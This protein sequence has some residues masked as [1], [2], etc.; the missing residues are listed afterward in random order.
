MKNCVA[1]ITKEPKPVWLNFLKTFK[2]LDVYLIID[3]NAIDYTE[4][5]GDDY[6]NIHFIQ[7]ENDLMR[8]SGFMN[9]STTTGMPSI[10]SWDKALYYFGV[11]N[12]SYDNVWFIEDDVFFYDES[13]LTRLDSKYTKSDIL[14]SKCD[15]R[16]D[17]E[18]LWS[19]IQINF[20]QP[21]YCAMV[22]GVRM[23]KTLLGHI[24]NYAKKNDTLFCLEAMFTS[25]A[26][27]H[28]LVLD[29]PDE[30]KSIVYQR[31]WQLNDINRFNIYHPVKI[32]SQHEE[33]RKIL[34]SGNVQQ[35]IP[36]ISQ[37][38]PSSSNNINILQK[39][40]TFSLRS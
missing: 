9:S 2:Q 21:H 23:S 13:T 1:I 38:P 15:S 31:D 18:W 28:K 29:I 6:P 12:T 8:D 24:S 20:P 30:M 35:P 17:G 19:R 34:A 7:L 16:K 4:F 22:C 10:I 25:V 40:L 33:F 14:V 5:Y 39:G 36:T 26:K 11:K 27:H 3:E 37:P 32:M